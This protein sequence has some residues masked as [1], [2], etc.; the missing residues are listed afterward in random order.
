MQ[1]PFSTNFVRPGKLE[2]VFTGDDS[3]ETVSARLAACDWR[4]QILGPHG[5]GKSTLL[6]NLTQQL[7]LQFEVTCLQPR[8]FRSINALPRHLLTS[9]SALFAIDGLELLAKRDQRQLLN[10]ARTHQ[11]GLLITTHQPVALPILYRTRPT[12]TVFQQ[13]VQRLL[14]DARSVFTQQEMTQTFE[15]HK[16]NIREALFAM[17]DKFAEATL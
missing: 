8:E 10:W 13:I 6:R 4:A 2:F 7:Q 3:L 5:S 9:R 17:Y 1:N 12:S 16:G 11:V 15:K 14:G